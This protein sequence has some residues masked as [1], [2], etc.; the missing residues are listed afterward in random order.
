MQKPLLAILAIAL[1]TLG[2]GCLTPAA[3]D[4]GHRLEQPTGIAAVSA[5]NDR[6]QVIVRYHANA[7][8]YGSPVITN[9]DDPI[10]RPRTLTIPY[11][12]AKKCSQLKV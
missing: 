3:L 11:Q 5:D 6:Q 4:I 10:S 12:A 9:V 7:H 1:F 2:A 8:R